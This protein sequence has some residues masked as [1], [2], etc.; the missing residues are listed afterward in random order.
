MDALSRYRWRGN[1]REL[2]NTVERL[3]I[4]TPADAVRVE[5]LPSEIRNARRPRLGRPCPRQPH[6]QPPPPKYISGHG[7]ED[8]RAAGRGRHAS[9][10]QGCRRARVSRPE[11]AR[12]QLEHL[13]DGGDH[14]HAAQQSLQEART[15]RHQAGSRRVE[16][17]RCEGAKVPTCDNGRV[18]VGQTTARRRASRRCGERKVRT[19]KGSAPGNARA[20]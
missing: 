16:V 12:E 7:A 4:M 14:R 5:D 6:Q 2:R 1:I 10:V 18:A 19:P 15:V 8:R 17:R 11:A 9:R 13:E 20:G 3:M